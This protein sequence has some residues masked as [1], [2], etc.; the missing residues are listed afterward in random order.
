MLLSR[1]FF[2]LRDELASSSIN[3]SEDGFDFFDGQ[4][5]RQSFLSPLCQDTYP[6]LRTMK[7]N[8][9]ETTQI[10]I[11]RFLLLIPEGACPELRKEKVLPANHS[12]ERRRG[13]PGSSGKLWGAEL[14]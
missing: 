10:Q 6:S 8:Q 4:Q 13:R 2:L 9:E 14:R 12:T 1:L 3:K 11:C 5:P 7:G